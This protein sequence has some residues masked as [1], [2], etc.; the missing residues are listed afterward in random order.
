MNSIANEFIRKSSFSGT[1]P[2]EMANTAVE[3]TSA[4]K[5]IIPKVRAMARDELYESS[6]T[7]DRTELLIGKNEG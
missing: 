7:G 6:T 1:I 5:C 3:K 2:K 4:P